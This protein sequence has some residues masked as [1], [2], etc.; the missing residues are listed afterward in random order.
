M[1]V[2]QGILEGMDQGT[3]EGV[4]GSKAVLVEGKLLVLGIELDRPEKE[5]TLTEMTDDQLHM[6]LHFYSCLQTDPISSHNEPFHSQGNFLGV[7]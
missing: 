6:D 5:T 7:C 3:P 2:G 1:G 4:V